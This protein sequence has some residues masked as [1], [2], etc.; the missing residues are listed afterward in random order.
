MFSFFNK[1]KRYSFVIVDFLCMIFSYAIIPFMF[2]EQRGDMYHLFSTALFTWFVYLFYMFAFGCYKNLLKYS[3]I[4]EIVTLMAASMATFITFFLTK[5]FASLLLLPT[6]YVFVAIVVSMVLTFCARISVK[7]YSRYV[8]HY[9]MSKL[10]N[11]LLIIGGGSAGSLLLEEIKTNEK[12]NFNPVGFIDDNPSKNGAMIG[13]IKILGTRKDIATIC[14]KY[15]IT[16]IIIAIPSLEETELQ[17]LVKIC[18]ETKCKVQVLPGYEKILRERT[19]EDRLTGYVRDVDIE[20]LLERDPVVL[21]NDE[22]N[23]KL[24][25]KVVLVTGGGGSIGSELCRQ[26]VK[27]SPKKLVIVDIYENNAYDIQLELK[28]NY[29]NLDLEVAIASVRDLKKMEVIFEK[30]RPYA[31][32]HAAAHKHV[33]LMED[34]PDEAIKNNVFGTY[35]CAYCADKY[36]V[37]GFTLIS[38]DKAVNPTNI[39]GASKRICEMVVQAFQT[40]SK[41]NFSAVRFGNVLGSNGSVI[42]LFKKQ[43]ARGGPVTV[44]HK[45]ITRY[46]MT[47]PEASQLV[48]QASAFAEGGEIFVLDMGKPV[49][50]YHLA[51][52]LIRLSGYEPDQ[53]IKIEITGL[54]HGEKLYEEL[55]MAEEGLEKTSNS[56][57]FIGQ[58]LFT[59]FE[60][61][62][63]KLEKLKTTFNNPDG[64]KV[65]E[66]V[67]QI[68]STYRPDYEKK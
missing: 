20:D 35:N 34:A 3:T 52:K 63:M 5:I 67:S 2:R 14:Q 17:K 7:Y 60:D 61:L 51:Q 39:M 50:I 66:V 16:N 4:R 1:Y 40:V 27:F 53:D 28:R 10:K 23:Q 24:K 41:T 26:I 57:I 31:V 54:R 38:T 68:V 58:P 18:S 62:N 30:Y 45:E 47:I 42:P 8:R 48:L 19:A 65:K 64:N 9:E 22:L 55:L 43:I 25:D 13:G 11:R 56:K 29:P 15:E 59:D 49:K 21:D 37:D 36:G 12:M 46:F 6:V 33:P 44:T 32:Y